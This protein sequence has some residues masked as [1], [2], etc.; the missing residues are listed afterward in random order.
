MSNRIRRRRQ[1]QSNFDMRIIVVAVALVLFLAIA[2][3]VWG[4]LL[5]GFTALLIFFYKKVKD[6]QTHAMRIALI[7]LE[8]VAWVLF[9]L[10]AV[11]MNNAPKDE[12]AQVKVEEPFSSP[13]YL[14]PTATPV[15][16][17]PLSELTPESV[18]HIYDD[19][20]TKDVMD[21][22]KVKKI[23]EFSL[24]R[25]SSSDVTLEA[26]N[27]W[28]YNYVKPNS[29][30]WCMILYMDRDDAFGVYS[31]NGLVQKDI[32][33]E[34]YGPDDYGVGAPTGETITY[35]PGNNGTLHEL[36]AEPNA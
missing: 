11:V 2:G 5:S 16:E 9:F 34:V 7:V 30:K 4:I 14:E 12:G 6:N 21:G 23:G 28:Y 3:P 33:F 15:Q 29:F 13:A 19:A 24:I 17:T 8:S 1:Q 10:I 26:L 20:E 25:V 18:A 36:T 27:D 22:S 31:A 32:P 35:Y